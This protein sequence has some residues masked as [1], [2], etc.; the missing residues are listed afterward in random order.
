MQRPIRKLVTAPRRF[1]LS[2]QHS[3]TRLTSRLPAK[4]YEAKAGA[5]R[6][7]VVSRRTR[8][9]VRGLAMPE[10]RRLEIGAT[11]SYHNFAILRFIRPCVIYRA[12]GR[13][14]PKAEHFI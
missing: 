10:V 3:L 11:S 8:Q 6:L 14:A 12:L 1:E 7:E 13:S 4:G 2:G 9:R 5:L